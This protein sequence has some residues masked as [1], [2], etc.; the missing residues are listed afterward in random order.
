MKK[1]EE[2]RLLSLELEKNFIS[3]MSLGSEFAQKII[4]NVDSRYFLNQETKKLFEIIK[5]G[6]LSEL[7]PID[8]II[9][10]NLSRLYAECLDIGF[11][12]D[13]LQATEKQK[14]YWLRTEAMKVVKSFEGNDFERPQETIGQLWTSLLEISEGQDKEKVE[15][16]DVMREYDAEQAI[17]TQKQKDGKAFIGYDIGFEKANELADGLRQGHLWILGA[18]T[19]G[20]KTFWSLN[21]VA[22]LLK[23]GVP[24]AFYSLEM[25]KVDVFGR[26]LG[27]LSGVNSRKILKGNLDVYEA[28]KVEEAR[29]LIEKSGFRIHTEKNNLTE[30]M[31]S[32]N[33]EGLTGRAKVF[34]IDYAQLVTTNDSSEYDTMRN[35]STQLQSFC[36]KKNMPVILLSQVSNEN[37]KD[38]NSSMIGFKGSGAL[39]A[40]ADIA[41]EMVSDDSKT[42]REEKIANKQPLNIKMC[43]KKNRHGAIR[44][45]SCEFNGTNGR[46]TEK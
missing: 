3:G 9:S 32:M 41:I 36:R 10:E 14:G 43:V 5:N 42:D 4:V 44:N 24:V 12:S 30:M 25:S 22:N 45:I 15:I 13:V 34:V 1:I 18:Y 40:S 2:I 26:L 23:Q 28:Q 33:I 35:L 11:Y 38:P 21:V 19:S 8:T 20:G 31:T 27:I 29:K 7:D 16:Q 17:F 39:G 6:V 37:A 46:F